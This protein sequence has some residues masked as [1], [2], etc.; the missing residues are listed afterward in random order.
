MA[1]GILLVSFH[2]ELTTARG[3]NT[4]L[5]RKEAQATIVATTK[6]TKAQGEELKSEYHQQS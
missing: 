2:S 4:Y 6:Q 3:G 1:A 5:R